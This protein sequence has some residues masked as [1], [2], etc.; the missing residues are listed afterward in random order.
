MI[1]CTPPA[2]VGAFIA[3]FHLYSLR[4]DRNLSG[5]ITRKAG[6]LPRIFCVACG[7]LLKGANARFA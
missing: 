1:T 5:L 6:I 2:D 3:R 4:E 7:R